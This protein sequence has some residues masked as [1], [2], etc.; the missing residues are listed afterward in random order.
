M[1][2]VEMHF[3]FQLGRSFDRIVSR[4]GLGPVVPGL[5]EF[6]LGRSFDRIVS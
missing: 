4:I 5:R 1:N 2:L 3:A 6:Q